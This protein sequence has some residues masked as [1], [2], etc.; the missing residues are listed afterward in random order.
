MPT[1]SPTTRALIERE[2]DL[3][4]QRRLE[5]DARR[6]SIVQQ[7][8]AATADVAA[9][10]EQLQQLRGDLGDPAEAGGSPDEST[11]EQAGTTEHEGDT[12]TPSW[13][14]VLVIADHAAE[15]HACAYEAGHDGDHCCPHVVE[16]ER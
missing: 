16:V 9:L 13:C 6:S 12:V 1:I 14:D 7:L 5:A 15:P 11:S 10:D 4:L 3:L 8:D 2:R